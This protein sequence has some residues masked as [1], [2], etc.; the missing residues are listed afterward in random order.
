MVSSQYGVH[1]AMNMPTPTVAASFHPLAAKAIA[2]KRR[3][4]SPDGRNSSAS[5]SPV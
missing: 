2:A 4:M 1:A 3:T 5:V